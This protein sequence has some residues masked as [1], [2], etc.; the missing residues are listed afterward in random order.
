V[1]TTTSRLQP[2]LRSQ[3]R[4]LLDEIER[5][6]GEAPLSENKTMRLDGCLDAREYV[7]SDDDGTVLGYG[8]AA[9][10]RGPGAEAGHWA[11][12]VAVAPEYRS[13]GVTAQLIE[14]IRGDIGAADMTLW[15]RTG[16]AAD[17][18]AAAGWIVQ[19]TL[20]EMQCAL[21]VGDLG[22][23]ALGLRLATF[24]MGADENAW[25][26]ANN[27]AF[28]G[29][30]ENGG[31]TRRDLERRMAQPWFDPEGFF[32]AW[33]GSAVAGSC[34]TKV[35]ESGTGEIYVIGVV[36]SWVG[37]GLGRALV[38]HGLEYLHSRRHVATAV[39]FVESDNE[40]ATNLYEGL[41]FSVVRSLQAYIHAT[42]A[43]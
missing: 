22:D 43:N 4:A 15:A 19:R 3:V 24:R 17:A 11:L 5:V 13:A 14:M 8:Q 40:R 39:L 1:P 42:G 20:W 33:D 30:P 28:A 35:H 26:E 25:L 38:A 31:M 36:P 41:G 10:H 18:A 34:W 2:E 6:D 7:A 9:W 21:P 29:H 37:R 32:I 23:T 16:F 12:E 27:A